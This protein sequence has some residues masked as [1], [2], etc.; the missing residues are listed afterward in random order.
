M[1][2]ISAQKILRSYIFNAS[3]KQFIAKLVSFRSMKVQNSSNF[4]MLFNIYKS[5]RNLF[6]SLE[7][8]DLIFNAFFSLL[9]FQ[10]MSF[11]F[12][13]LT[14]F[15]LASLALGLDNG[16]ARTPPMGWLSWE[17]FRCRTDCKLY[18]NS[19]IKLVQ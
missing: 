12:I 18:P 16:L 2:I 1:D 5:T 6:K 11:Q 14:A 15:A 7:L 3:L 8:S 17:R 13:L 19:C 10:D 4:Q 9:F